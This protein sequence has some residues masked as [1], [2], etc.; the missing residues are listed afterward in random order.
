MT[1]LLLPRSVL[2]SLAPAHAN[3]NCNTSPN[4]YGFS[5]RT[6]TI[7]RGSTVIWTNSTTA[8]HTVSSDLGD[9]VSFD[10]GMQLYGPPNP[11]TY[12]FTF[13]VPGTYHYHCNVHAYMTAT[14]IVTG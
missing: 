14:I 4:P 10:S 2:V 8:P 13:T 12:S 7:P 11:N 3:C 9:P 5:P 1:T 6:I